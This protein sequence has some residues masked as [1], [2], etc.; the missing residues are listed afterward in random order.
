MRRRRALSLIELLVVIAIIAVLIALLLPA[1]Q[2]ARLSA[3]RIQ[4]LNNMKQIGLAAHL[5][6]DAVGILPRYRYCPAP[7]MDG[8]FPPRTRR[9][10][11]I[12]VRH[13]RSGVP[14]SVAL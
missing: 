4:C 9:A 8:R 2:K 3:A 11:P 12:L 5:Y 14:S 10:L 1:V 6:H 13:A 7:W